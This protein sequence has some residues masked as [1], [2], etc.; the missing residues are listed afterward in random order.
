MSVL[1]APVGATVL[2]PTSRQPW[3]NR[4]RGFFTH[5]RLANASF[6]LLLWL[7]ARLIV[8]TI[9]AVI[10]GAQGDVYYYYD[11]VALVG[12]LGPA[13]LMQEYPTPAVLFLYLPYLLGGGSEIG[14]VIAFVVINLVLDAAFTYSLWLKGG[15]MRGQAVLF[16]TLFMTFIGPTAYLRFDLATAVPCGWALMFL[17]RRHNFIAG[18][19]VGLGASFKLW[20]ALLWPALLGGSRKH[21]T[22]VTAGVAS[23]GIVLAG[24]SLAWGGWARLISPLSYQGDRGLQ[25]ESIWATVPML[26]RALGLGD[27]AVAISRWQAFEVWGSDVPF[28]TAAASIAGACGYLLPVIA[29]AAWCLRG[30]GRMFEATALMLLTITAL[31]VSNKTFSPQYVIWLAPTMAAAF[32]VLGVRSPWQQNYHHDRNLLKRLSSLMLG[33][34]LLTTLVYPISYSILVRDQVGWLKYL[35]L[36]V[37]LVLVARNLL[38]LWFFVELLRWVWGF[39]NP[40][41][42]RT[43][44]LTKTGAAQGEM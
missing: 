24:I 27:Y 35:Q 37:T 33:F 36:P 6:L 5:E 12:Q 13:Q 18:G 44:Q 23:V 39:L 26:E 38:V 40:D 15:R 32:T 10:G 16:W 28:W 17:L 43:I 29:G 25:V 4:A 20:P 30:Q 11:R 3:L 31:I 41:H 7:G 2:N 8:F 22:T 21:N 9:W 42:F 14:Y 19:L 34:T 1:P